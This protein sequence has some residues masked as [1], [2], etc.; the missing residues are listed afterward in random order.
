MFA[1]FQCCRGPYWGHCSNAVGTLSGGGY[2]QD[3]PLRVRIVCPTCSRPAEVVFAQSYTLA[4]L[5]RRA[6]LAM[7]LL[8]L[9]HSEL[10]TPV[11]VVPGHWIRAS[12]QCSSAFELTIALSSALNTD[13]LHLGEMTSKARVDLL[14]DLDGVSPEMREHIEQSVHHCTFANACV[15]TLV[16]D[17][18]LV[19]F[20]H[21]SLPS[22]P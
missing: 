11:Q 22:E 16:A 6:R 1:F 3:S 2:R 14:R 9:R 15:G 13:P 19:R 20:R 21:R 7:G 4:C 8:T 10:L 18:P 12:A 17:F 5:N